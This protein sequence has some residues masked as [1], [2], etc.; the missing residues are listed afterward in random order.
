MKGFSE[1]ISV[2]ILI[3]IAILIISIFILPW[4]MKVVTEYTYS[5]ERK[6]SQIERELRCGLKIIPPPEHTNFSKVPLVVSNIGDVLVHEVKGYVIDKN[7]KII[8]LDWNKH[9]YV[10]GNLVVEDINTETFDLPPG[11]SILTFISPDNNT[12]E[13][14]VIIIDGRECSTYYR[15]P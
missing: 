4:V 11:H 3:L 5:V 9:I 12:F 10:K 13:G 7:N 6:S 2:L 15:Y 1:Q 8:L 14:F